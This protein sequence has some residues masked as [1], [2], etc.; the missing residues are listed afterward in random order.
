MRLQFDQER[1]LAV[2][3][4][5]DDAELLCAGTLARARV[6]GAEIGVC[7]LCQG[8]KGSPGQ[9]A[10]DLVLKRRRESETAAKLLGATLFPGEIP[11]A[12]LLETEETRSRMVEVLRRF[13]PTLV[14]AHWKDDYHPDHQVASRLAE[15][16]TWLSASRGFMT[17][18]PPLEVSPT[19]WWMDTLGMMGFEPAF[20]VDISAHV[21]LK[22]QL[23]ACHQTQLARAGDPDFTHL[24]DLM[25]NQMYTRG[26]QSGVR[27]AEGFRAHLA[28]KRFRAW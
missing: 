10:G 26:Q 2:V 27:A 28:F 23:L 11:D 19:L 8:D 17:G 14:L 22:E 3:A 6:D 18:S 9:L 15:A 21:E 12:M 5:P 20:S 25:K 7:V 13:R 16:T 4:H 24:M 1:V